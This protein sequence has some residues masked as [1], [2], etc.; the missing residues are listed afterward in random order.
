MILKSGGE[1]VPQCCFVDLLAILDLFLAFQ[2]DDI[3]GEHSCCV[4]ELRI[5]PLLAPSVLGAMMA[6][7]DTKAP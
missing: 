2:I 6:G 3:Y 1:I 5:G 4:Q 7:G